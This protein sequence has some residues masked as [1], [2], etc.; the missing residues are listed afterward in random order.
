MDTNALILMQLPNRMTPKN[1]TFPQAG[2]FYLAHFWLLRTEVAVCVGDI[3]T[4]NA[5][6]LREFLLAETLSRCWEQ[7]QQKN[8]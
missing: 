5:I 6:V 2:S 8:R 3:K 1:A 7:Q 4:P